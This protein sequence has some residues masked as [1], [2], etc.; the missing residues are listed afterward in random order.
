[1]P[2]VVV[3]IVGAGLL[4]KVYSF[5]VAQPNQTLRIQQ[6]MVFYL[7]TSLTSRGICAGLGAPDVI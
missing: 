7:Y 2:L 4:T 5:V 6:A 1:M 3:P